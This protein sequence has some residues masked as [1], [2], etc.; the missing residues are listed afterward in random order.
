MSPPGPSHATL[1]QGP[2]SPLL[3]RS[4][5]GPWPGLQGLALDNSSLGQKEG[6]FPARRGT[7][8]VGAQGAEGPSATDVQV[9]AVERQED[10]DVVLTVTLGKEGG[11]CQIQTSH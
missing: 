10:L 2:F 9:A 3:P 7:H 11:E 5:A 1:L 6:P 4:L 8:H